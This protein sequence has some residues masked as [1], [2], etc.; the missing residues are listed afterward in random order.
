MKEVVLL[1]EEHLDLDP[2]WLRPPPDPSLPDDPH[3]QELFAAAPA[4][5]GSAA[6]AWASSWG[7]LASPSPSPSSSPSPSPCLAPE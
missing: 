5:A 2:A 3:G 1:L 4:A 6:W 7:R